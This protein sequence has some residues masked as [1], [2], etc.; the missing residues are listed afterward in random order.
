MYA[1][2]DGL[3]HLHRYLKGD[4]K[5][6][7]GKKWYLPFEK[8]T[9]KHIFIDC[10]VKQP[11]DEALRASVSPANQVTVAT[12][13]L[14][15]VFATISLLQTRYLMSGHIGM[16]NM[17]SQYPDIVRWRRKHEKW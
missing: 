10:L 2:S 6:S 12:T 8:S 17:L 7:I 9:F 15:A 4:F 3:Q 1:W 14:T 11:T 13:L 16:T 5:S